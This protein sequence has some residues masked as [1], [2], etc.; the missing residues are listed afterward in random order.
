MARRQ[1]PTDPV[2]DLLARLI[3]EGQVASTTAKSIHAAHRAVIDSQSDNH[4]V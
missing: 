1:R 2:K 4:E 3:A